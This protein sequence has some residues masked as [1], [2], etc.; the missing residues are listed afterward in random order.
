MSIKPRGYFF[1]TVTQ[2]AERNIPWS[3][4]P[5]KSTENLKFLFIRRLFPSCV[6]RRFPTRHS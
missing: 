3:W 2:V 4:V 6:L 5:K 1:V